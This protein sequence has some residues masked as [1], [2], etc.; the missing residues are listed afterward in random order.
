MKH[1]NRCK[2]CTWIFLS[3]RG[4]QG[5]SWFCSQRRRLW[6]RSGTL[7]RSTRFNFHVNFLWWAV[8]NPP[9]FNKHVAEVSNFFFILAQLVQSETAVSFMSNLFSDVWIQPSLGLWQLTLAMAMVTPTTYLAQ[10]FMFTAAWCLQLLVSSGLSSSIFWDLFDCLLGIHP[11]ARTLH[12]GFCFLV[13]SAHEGIQFPNGSIKR[14]I[15]V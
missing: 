1:L 14:S 5:M 9:F 15:L 7:D 12:L 10:S 8:A 6:Y 4:L 2:T 3:C 13:K 11:I